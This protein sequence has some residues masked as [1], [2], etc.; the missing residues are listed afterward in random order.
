M[1]SMSPLK[2]TSIVAT[3]AFAL[4]AVVLGG[5]KPL[6]PATMVRVAGDAAAN[7]RIAAENTRRAAVHTEA[8][9]T[10]AENVRS[11][12]N[13]SEHM[14]QTQLELEA[15][16]RSSVKRSLGLARSLDQIESSLRSLRTRLSAIASLSADTV[17]DGEAAAD[18]ADDLDSVLET[19]RERF[20]QVMDES[21]ELNRKARGYERA[22]P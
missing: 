19:L 13:T 12:L 17:V 18:A 6:S 16:S 20:E 3:L 15:S 10:I 8:F 22:R 9:T 5:G 1:R 21:R 4:G 11:Q 14:L 2:V 7:S